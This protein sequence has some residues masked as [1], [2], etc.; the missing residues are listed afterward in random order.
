MTVT[1]QETNGH[2]PA[3]AGDFDVIIVGAGIS[4]I[5]A[6]YRIAERNPRMTYAILERR[7]RIGD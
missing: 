2:P 1:P 4:G 6:A 7:E 3:E 5:G